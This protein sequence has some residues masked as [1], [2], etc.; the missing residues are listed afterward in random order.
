MDI[1]SL[2]VDTD[3]DLVCGITSTLS[4]FAL[5]ELGPPLLTLLGDAMVAL[6]LGTP[7]AD[8]GA[9]ARDGFANDLTEEIEVAGTV[10]VNTPGAYS[11]SYSVS[12]AAGT[13]SLTRAVD[14][15]ITPNSYSLLAL[16]SVDLQ[17][18]SS[19]HSGFVG[20]QDFGEPPFAGGRTELTLG[21]SA[22]TAEEVRVSAPR[23]ELK[24]GAAIMGTLYSSEPPKTGKKARIGRQELVDADYWPLVELPEFL[25][26]QPGTENVRVDQKKSTLLTP[27]HYAEVQVRQKGTLTFSGG[28]YHL[29]S[30]E[31]GQKSRLLFDGPTTLTIEGTLALDQKSFFGPADGSTIDAG[32]IVVYV[33]GKVEKRNAQDRDDDDEDGDDDGER[34]N[35]RDRDEKEENDGRKKSRDDDDEDSDGDRKKGRDNDDDDENRDEDDDRGAGKDGRKNGKNDDDDENGKGRRSKPAPSKKSIAAHLGAQ[36]EFFGNIYAPEGIILM[37]QGSQSTGSFIGWDLLLGNKA[38]VRL[39]SGWKT[40]GVI[41]VPAGD[42]PAKEL[43]GEAA[44]TAI[45]GFRLAQNRPNPFNA[46]T[47]IDYQLETASD[48]RLTIYNVL[49]QPVR[50]LVREFQPRGYYRVSWNGRSDSGQ[51]VSNGLYFYR[52]ISDEGVRTRRMLLL[53]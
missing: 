26:S 38:E 18:N 36:V 32:D 29:T 34:E 33:T 22:R 53:K 10:D 2:P 42:I 13:S 44:A 14:V 9:T 39:R 47:T 6:E 24:Q 17:Q 45:A 46:T 40:P 49:G 12:N 20:V 37:Q 50:Q 4:P 43:A 1:T 52:L 15:V 25:A 41:Y 28:E 16:H 30:L 11:I 3:N 5:F 23:A 31:A 19:V 21:T 27:G 8:P 48:V 7:F 51:Q 35:R